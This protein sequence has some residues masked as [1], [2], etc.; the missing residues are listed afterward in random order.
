[1]RPE[2]KAKDRVRL[3][4]LAQSISKQFKFNAS[5][6]IF[7]IYAKV[8]K[9]VKL[10][11]KRV[12]MNG[13]VNLKAAK[14]VRAFKYEKFT[15]QPDREKVERQLVYGLNTQVPIKINGFVKTNG[16]QRFDVRT[17]KWVPNASNRYIGN[18]WNYKPSLN[19]NK[20][21]FIN[22]SIWNDIPI[23]N[24]LYGYK[25]SRDSWVPARVLEEVASI[26]FVGLEKGRNL[27]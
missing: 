17:K 20:L 5:D 15:V 7:D 23:V 3:I 10:P 8:V 27:I 9:K 19:V 1:L 11:T 16:R 13:K 18:E 2:K 25:R 22:Q 21:N 24:T 12:V 6:S 26:P 14:R 4:K